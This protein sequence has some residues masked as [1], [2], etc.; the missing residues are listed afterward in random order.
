MSSL[1]NVHNSLIFLYCTFVEEIIFLVAEGI[2]I[3]NQF[4]HLLV[5][6]IIFLIKQSFIHNS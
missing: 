5:K 1:L 3:V 6:Q 4:L 2:N